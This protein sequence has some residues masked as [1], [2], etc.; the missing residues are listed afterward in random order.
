MSRRLGASLSP[1]DRL[2]AFEARIRAYQ[3][4]VAELE[5]A[6]TTLDTAGPR[7]LDVSARAFRRAFVTLQDINAT[8]IR[9]PVRRPETVAAAQAAAERDR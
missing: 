4:A 6:W 9:T 3:V 1:A 2:V 7:Q 8:P 5:D